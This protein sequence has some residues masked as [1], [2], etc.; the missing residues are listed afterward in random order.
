MKRLGYYA[1]SK[2]TAHLY[3]FEWTQDDKLLINNVE[4]DPS[5][6]EILE[7][8]FFTL[9]PVIINQIAERSTLKGKE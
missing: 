7:I 4:V 3:Q 9:S 5:R 6:Y 1:K 8:G 2:A